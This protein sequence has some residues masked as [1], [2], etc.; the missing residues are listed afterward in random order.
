MRR[1]STGDVGDFRLRAGFP[2]YR[3]MGA[4][5]FCFLWNEEG[6]V[7]ISGTVYVVPQIHYIDSFVV[8]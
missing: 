6:D 5:V 3:G 1:P 8:F 4:V 2:P 7:A